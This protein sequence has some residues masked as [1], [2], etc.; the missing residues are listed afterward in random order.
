MNDINFKEKIYNPYCEIWKLLKL[1]QH[2]TSRSGDWDLYTKEV[3]RFHNEHKGSRFAEDLER[4][5]HYAEET[6]KEMNNNGENEQ[7]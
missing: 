5:L 1:L 3:A 4:F 6:I 2:C 7:H